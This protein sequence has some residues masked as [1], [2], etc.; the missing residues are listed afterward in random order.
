MITQTI[1]IVIVIKLMIIVFMITIMIMIMIIIIIM[2]MKIMI[3]GR[4]D[5]APGGL[6]RVL[7][8]GMSICY[9]HGIIR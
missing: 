3:G 2:I 9:S 4:R 5:P 6:P 7:L 1:Q 8:Q